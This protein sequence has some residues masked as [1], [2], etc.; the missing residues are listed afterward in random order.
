MSKNGTEGN[1]TAIAKMADSEDYS[2]P[3]DDDDYDEV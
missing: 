3:E 1:A 2:E